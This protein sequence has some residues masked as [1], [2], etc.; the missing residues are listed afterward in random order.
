MAVT[1]KA[2]ID[3]VERNREE[4]LGKCR[5]ENMDKIYNV[6]SQL[7]EPYMARIQHIQSIINHTL[8]NLQDVLDDMRNDPEVYANVESYYN[9]AKHLYNISGDNLLKHQVSDI[10][11]YPGEIQKLTM[12]ME[13]DLQ[14]IKTQYNIVIANCKSIRSNKE[15]LKY[16][17][18][19]GFDT[20]IL[21]SGNTSLTIQV[22]TSKLYL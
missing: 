21:E 15:C 19:L 5:K 2:I 7:L 11:R 1:K 9:P 22:D 4:A 3:L 6:K 18:S 20:T 10:C 17:K 8:S 12:A 14:D 13:K 16:L